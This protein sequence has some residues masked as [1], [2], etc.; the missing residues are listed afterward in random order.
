MAFLG[1]TLVGIYLGGLLVELDQNSAIL[2]QVNPDQIQTYCIPHVNKNWFRIVSFEICA[3]GLLMTIVVSIYSY[4]TICIDSGETILS[5]AVSIKVDNFINFFYYLAKALSGTILFLH[6]VNDGHCLFLMFLMIQDQFT[7]S[8][9]NCFT[10][11]IVFIYMITQK[12]VQIL[13]NENF[14]HLYEQKEEEA[15]EN[16]EEIKIIVKT[17]ERGNDLING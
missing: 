1:L 8:A 2:I 6:G 3:L 17:N 13:W 4:K 7:N 11:T 16:N 15:T 5:S 9:Y 12:S 14:D 10:I